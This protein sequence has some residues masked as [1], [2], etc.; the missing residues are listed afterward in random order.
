MGPE[1]HNVTKNGT[2]NVNRPNTNIWYLFFL[3]FS[4][5]ISRPAK[6]MM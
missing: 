2:M 1:K 5:S 4:T 6:N 3:M